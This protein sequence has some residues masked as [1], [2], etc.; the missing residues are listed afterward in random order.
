MTTETTPTNETPATEPVKVRKTKAPKIATGAPVEPK[1]V[2][3]ANVKKAIQIGKDMS[4]QPEVS[5]AD[6]ARAMFEL[7]ADEPR[8][9][10][11]QAFVE[12]AGLT[13]KGS[14]TYYYNCKRKAAKAS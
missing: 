14:V 9:V 4:K 11:A 1:P 10:V 8:E 7:I 12:G 3:P 6:V 5:K 2:N 13:P